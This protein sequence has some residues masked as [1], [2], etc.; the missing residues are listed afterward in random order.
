MLSAPRVLEPVDD[1]V[2]MLDVVDVSTEFV[3]VFG[4]SDVVE[5]LLINILKFIK[6]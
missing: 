6:F 1:S 5:F 2:D 4:G 3:V